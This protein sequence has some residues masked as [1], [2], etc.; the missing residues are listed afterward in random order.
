MHRSRSSY[1]AMSIM[2]DTGAFKHIHHKYT[3]YLKNDQIQQSYILLPGK[4]GLKLLFL[5]ALQPLSFF[6]LTYLFL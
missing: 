3:Y 6:T 1:S 2:E 4:Y 5:S